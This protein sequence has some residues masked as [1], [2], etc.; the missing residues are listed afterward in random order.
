MPVFLPVKIPIIKLPVSDQNSKVKLESI[1][2][3]SQ[4]SFLPIGQF[5]AQTTDHVAP[6]MDIVVSQMAIVIARTVS[7]L[8]G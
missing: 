1:Q 8:E 5:E 7:I 6:R 4:C 2:D 3:I